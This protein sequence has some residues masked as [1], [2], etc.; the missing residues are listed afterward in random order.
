MATTRRVPVPA[1]WAIHALTAS[2]AVIAFVA[3]LAVERG[4]YRMALA[5]LALGLVVDGA[6][7]PLARWTGLA[8]RMPAIDGAILDL[9]VDYLTYVFVPAVL[10]YRAGLLPDAWAAVG[11]AAILLS[12]LYTFARTDMK[13]EDNFFRGFPAVWNVIAFYL[14]L[15]RPDVW[16]SAGVVALFT[17]LTFAPIHF[18]HP[19]RVRSYRPWLTILMPVWAVT[20]LVLLWP[21]VPYAHVLA[22]V[23]LGCALALFG[24]GLL[25]TLRG[26]K[27]GA[28]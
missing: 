21:G 11:A 7:G 13:T 17:V 5:W 6:D 1:L 28:P 9:V 14:F 22:E 26:P 20:S 10:I 23:S 15:L 27:R 4:A 25:R 2:G 18:I 8:E 19:V 12:S 16:V 24:I 3:F